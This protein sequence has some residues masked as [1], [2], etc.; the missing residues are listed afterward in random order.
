M[1]LAG[2]AA[3]ALLGATAG[4]SAAE[5]T[6]GAGEGAG[7]GGNAGALQVHIE[8]ES[9]HVTGVGFLAGS[10]VEVHV[11][12]LTTTVTADE[13][14]VVDALVT[15]GSGDPVAAD[16]TAADGTARSLAPSVD[17]GADRTTA[18]LA[19]AGLGAAPLL[20][21]RRRRRTLRP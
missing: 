19:G 1:L 10:P 12:D 6:S 9:V 11:G 8:G 16:G 17:D 7:Y 18:T 3:G 21:A 15:A 20:L 2:V 13:F 14:G 4:W 5:A